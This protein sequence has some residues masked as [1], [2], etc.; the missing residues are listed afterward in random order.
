MAVRRDQSHCNGYTDILFFVR[1]LPPVDPEPAG[2]PGKLSILP[3]FSTL[4]FAFVAESKMSIIKH[5]HIVCVKC[6][7]QI[8]AQVLAQRDVFRGYMIM[9]WCQ[10]H[11]RTYTVSIR[12]ETDRHARTDSHTLTHTHTHTGQ[13][14]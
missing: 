10:V 13:I 4:G 11:R 2:S 5:I 1:T 3:L 14:N 8:A 9:P 7:V 6:L 12:T